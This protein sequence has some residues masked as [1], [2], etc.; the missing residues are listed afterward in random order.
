MRN[1]LLYISFFICLSES[2]HSQ[3]LSCKIFTTDQGLPSNEVYSLIQD[4]KGY[5]WGATDA[6]VFRYNGEYFKLFTSKEGLPGNT[7]LNL[8]ED[9]HGKIWMTFF[10][11]KIAYIENNKVYQI[12]ANTELAELL[13]NTLIYAVKFSDDH[14]IWAS[15]TSGKLLRIRP[16][17]NYK[18]VEEIPLEPGITFKEISKNNFIQC[19][20]NVWDK[21]DNF[22]TIDHLSSPDRFLTFNEKRIHYPHYRMIQIAKDEYL[23]NQSTN[24]NFLNQK[25]KIT[26]QDLGSEVNSL[27]KSN[28][29]TWASTVKN[30][31]FFFRNND[32]NTA[33]KQYLSDFNIT[34]MIQD[35]EGG[36]WFGTLGKGLVYCPNINVLHFLKNEGFSEKIISISQTASS[37]FFMNENLSIY[38]IK[39]DLTHSI[40]FK[41]KSP[42]IG[43]NGQIAVTKSGLKFGSGSSGYYDFST[44]NVSPYLYHNFG[45]VGGT[46]CVSV[47]DKNTIILSYIRLLFLENNKVIKEVSL[48][49]RGR[50]L[51]RTD[52][53]EIFVGTLTGLVEYRDGRFVEHMDK[54]QLLNIRVNHILPVGRVLILSTSGNGILIY[55]LDDKTIK[56]VTTNHGLNSSICH[57]SFFN[58]NQLF[59]GSHNGLNRIS[60]NQ[61]LF[62]KYIVTN[63]TIDDGLISNEITALSI[64]NN[65]LWVGTR[66]GL[67]KISDISGAFKLG[68]PRIQIESF[69]VNGKLIKNFKSEMF[70]RH[71]ENNFILNL[72]NLT[73]KN[74]YGP[75][76][77]FRLSGGENSK[78]QYPDISTISF[79]NLEPGAYTLF[80]TGVSPNN[81]YSQTPIIL[82]FT[83][84]L[85]YW[86]TWW[87]ILLMVVLG[88]LIMFSIIQLRV[89][90]VRLKSKEKAEIR[91]QIL[92]HQMLAMRAQMNPHFMFNAING[93]Q[94]YILENKSESAYKYLSKF[95]KLIR[96]ILQNSNQ[97]LIPV[98]K[99]V[100]NVKLYVELEQLRFDKAFDFHLSIDPKIDTETV[101]IPGMLIQ[102]FVENAIWHGLMPLDKGKQGVI[103]TSV[104]IENDEI[105]ITIEDNGI[106]RVKSQSNKNLET[107]KSMGIDI[108]LQRI[109]LI[110]E[111]SSIEYIDKYDE[112]NNPTG[113]IVK[114]NL[115]FIKDDHYE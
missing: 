65:D 26:S 63:Y 29:G 17:N 30:G 43:E 67:V 16:A 77:K 60:F 41:S 1:F 6:G 40:V 19:G 35:H 112:D 42:L 45:I 51:A 115:P 9:P 20:T 82:H 33:P 74:S 13:K 46:H 68:I 109:K 52:K 99:E 104:N 61:G 87:F 71:Y 84:K 70:F 92:E 31:L 93:I 86:K 85:P 72:S 39:P 79:Q 89:K 94:R 91:Q 66:K 14:S 76:F 97:N 10:N 53:G 106:G 107:H 80:I 3:D 111:R 108:S 18:K 96:E 54:A 32:F 49:N 27:L 23:F 100:S 36:M 5:I 4:S 113:T 78:Y 103:N 11:G 22:L 56:Q 75:K 105:I 69:R 34:T 47:D 55:H 88:L 48:P 110:D 62:S 12:A 38:Q 57:L 37:V 90:Q 15:E 28:E 7:A 21:K 58:K 50:S 73:F 95:S 44:K 102:P 114:I 25:G 64:H 24:V 8:M 83:V 98:E 2:F 101:L 59:V 81:A